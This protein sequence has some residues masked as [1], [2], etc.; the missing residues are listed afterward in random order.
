MDL[1]KRKRLLDV[2]RHREDTLKVCLLGRYSQTQTKKLRPCR[3][4]CFDGAQFLSFKV[5][6]TC[7]RLVDSAT[8]RVIYQLGKPRACPPLNKD[9]LALVLA[10]VDVR[11]L[12]RAMLV[13]RSW[14]SVAKQNKLWEPHIASK[15]RF[16]HS[17]ITP[18]HTQYSML[19]ALRR[20]PADASIFLTP[21][22]TYLFKAVIEGVVGCRCSS[23]GANTNEWLVFCRFRAI[24]YGIKRGDNSSVIAACT[25][26]F[27]PIVYS[28]ELFVRTFIK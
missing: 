3:R 23:F 2:I 1:K 20:R 9:C 22:G 28:L 21:V 24:C 5:W 13:S 16:V 14:R 12:G 18:L 8:N 17:Y 4:L 27:G 7:I 15:R 10:C 19:Q 25:D 26:A 6:D 11:T